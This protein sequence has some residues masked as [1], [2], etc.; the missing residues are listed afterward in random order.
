MPLMIDGGRVP[1][2]WADRSRTPAGA[3]KNRV[4][5]GE[6]VRI[7]FINNMPDA[8]LEETEMQFFELLDAA[9]GKIPLCVKLHALSGV[10]RGERGQEHLRQFY[11]DTESLGDHRFDAMIMTGTEPR[12]SDL[13]AEP[14]W[15]DLANVLN[16]AEQNTVSTILSCLAAHAGVLYS[17]GITRHLLDDK[18]FGVFAFDKTANHELTAGTGKVIRFPHS[19]WNEVPADALK[20]CGYRVLSQSAEGGVDS[21][22]KQKGR[23]LFLHFQGHPEYDAQTLLR[24]Y[25]RDIRRFLKKERDTY[26]AAPKG[27]FHGVGEKQA[28]GFQNAVLSVRR[29]ELR[30]ELLADFPEPVLMGTLLKTW[31]SSATIIYRNWIRFVASKKADASKLSAVAALSRDVSR[32]PLWS[33]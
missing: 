25:R 28:A 3:L 9:S 10:P 17:D 21:F 22:V 13:R 5:D 19:R 15:S 23:S 1:P 14:Y 20:G 2:R 31:N 32:K 4:P 18:R 27:Y 30:E 6:C 33:R 29:E 7:A 16:W 26:P 24:E 8:A 11:F 12:H